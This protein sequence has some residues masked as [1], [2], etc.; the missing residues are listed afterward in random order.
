MI[1]APAWASVL[2]P[3]IAQRRAELTVGGA[4]TS[5]TRR[6]NGEI[7]PAAAHFSPDGL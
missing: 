3:S 7:G 5:D 1:A 6:F 4:L 2:A